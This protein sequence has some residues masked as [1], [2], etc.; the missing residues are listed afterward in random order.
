MSTFADSQFS[1]YL[2]IVQSLTHQ[3]LGEALDSAFGEF[4][5]DAGGR[6]S[7]ESRH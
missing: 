2:L 7:T 6:R 1:G 5:D 4:P 3:V